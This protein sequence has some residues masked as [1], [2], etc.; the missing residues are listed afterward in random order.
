M[1]SSLKVT[2]LLLSLLLLFGRN[3]QGHPLTGREDGRVHN[4]RIGSISH[5]LFTITGNRTWFMLQVVW[6]LLSPQLILSVPC[7]TIM[8][9]KHF[10]NQH[11]NKNM[12]VVLK[13]VVFWHSPWLITTTVNNIYNSHCC[14]R[15]IQIKGVLL[16]CLS[17]R[18]ITDKAH[19]AK[20]Q[21]NIHYEYLMYECVYTG[22]WIY[23]HE[24]TCT[25]IYI[26]IYFPN[27]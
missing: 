3:L 11:L 18:T 21:F 9:L 25:C 4:N 12:F 20:L 22:I 2:S 17:C 14:H 10:T 7:Q 26:H 1:L 16:C 23:M 19:L 5:A 8:C 13:N 6:D 15:N 27:S 24:C